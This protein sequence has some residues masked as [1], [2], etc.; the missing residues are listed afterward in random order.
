[1]VLMKVYNHLP[2]FAQNVACFFEGTRIQKTRFSYDFWE[3]FNEFE[4]RKN[5]SYEQMCEFRDRRLREIV[6]HCYETV[7][8]YNRVF[9]QYGINYESI[10]TVDD[11]KKLPI[12][13]KEIVKK[14]PEDFISN[15]YQGKRLKVHT[16]GT[17]GS[18]LQLYCSPNTIHE[19]FAAFW[20]ARRNVGI[21]LGQWSGTMGGKSV[22]PQQQ[23]KP[24][25]WRINHPG[26]QV[27]FSVYHLNEESIEAYLYEIEK[28]KLIWIHAYPSAI[29]LIASYMNAHNRKLDHN[30]KFI[31]TGSENLMPSHRQS[32]HKAFGVMPYEHY[33]QMENVAIFSEREDHKIFVDE[34]FSAV[35]FLPDSKSGLFK[36]VGSSLNNYVMP[37]LRYDIGDIADMKETSQ[38]RQVLSIDGRREDYII[39]SNG[40]KIGRL[41]HVFSN[42]TNIYE[43]Q[44]I[45]KNIGEIK[46]KIVKGSNYGKEDE[47]V[48]LNKMRLKLG[49]SEK[50][51]LEY[52][53]E[54]PRTKNGKLRFVVSEL[55]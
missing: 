45:Q 23:K 35:E 53:D 6:K 18:G 2:I 14:N 43:A 40:N 22:V 26:K 50:I 13:T 28:R 33:G 29:N 34:D 39:L 49:D 25:F 36:I 32:I 51:A 47:S 46:I 1:M 54:I 17:T 10:R 24:P 38:G 55:K 37:L 31:T 11:L 3:V 27:Y 48:L 15:N 19:Q 42:M 12:L 5:W 8:Y 52:V 44:I 9:N 30:V 7:P 20:R 21:E 4:K 41:A 16:S